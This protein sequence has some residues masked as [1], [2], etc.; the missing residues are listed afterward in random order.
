V[1]EPKVAIVVINWNKLAVTGECLRALDGLDYGNRHLYVLDN[2][3]EEKG[4]R[5]VVDG[6]PGRTLIESATNLGYAGG[7]NLAMTRAFAEGAA[8]VWLLNNDCRPEPDA[9]ARLVRT[10]QSDARIGLVSPVLFREP[11][12][13]ALEVAGTRF[14][15]QNYG[16]DVT[17]SLEEAEAWQR[18][19]PERVA[20]YGTALLLSRAMYEKV[21][22]F[23]EAFFAYY[24]DT[25][26]SIRSAKAGFRNVLDPSARVYHRERP[27]TEG[28]EHVAPYL[29]YYMT[30]NKILLWTKHGRRDA[31]LRVFVW[32]F[33]R[34]MGEIASGRLHR[35]HPQLAQAILAGLWDGWRGVGGRYSADRR[36][37]AAMRMT[38]LASPSFWDRAVKFVT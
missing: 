19:S 32:E 36:A 38:L 6:R 2:G 28:G 10:A 17:M 37:P 33:S 30:R 11:G 18:A 14:D 27:R 23:D 29:L 34:R 26:L 1:P 3:S 8:F 5:E 24:E 4:I 35:R 7:N 15:L 21:G 13:A 22:G 16:V 20:L 25:D 12:S 31:R 9:L